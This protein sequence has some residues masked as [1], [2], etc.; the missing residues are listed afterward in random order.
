MEITIETLM[1]ER[2]Q[3][4][5]AGSCTLGRANGVWHGED[6]PV[7]FRMQ[8]EIDIDDHDAIT[9]TGFPPAFRISCSGNVNRVVGQVESTGDG[10]L[11]VRLGNDVFQLE[12]RQSDRYRQGDWIRIET[13]ELH[14][15]PFLV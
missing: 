1:P 8:V 7:P 5:A 13:S 12:V 10:M 4:R 15:Y 3:L 11:S 14:L 2:G 6:L 9:R